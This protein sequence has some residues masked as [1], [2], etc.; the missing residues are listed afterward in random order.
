VAG[1]AVLVALSVWAL[2]AERQAQAAR[3]DAEA[4]QLGADAAL[5]VGEQAARIE[6]SALLAIEA[7][8]RRPALGNDM[9]L[10]AALRLLPE[11]LGTWSHAPERIAAACLRANG[12]WLVYGAGAQLFRRRADGSPA[13]APLPLEA[14]V[15]AIMP[16]GPADAFVVRTARPGGPVRLR[17]WAGIDAE[18]LPLPGA[19]AAACSADGRL[20]AMGDASGRI[21]L[22]ALDGGAAPPRLAESLDGPVEL[23]RISADGRLLAASARERLRLWTLDSGRPL[24]A[25]RL[26]RPIVDLDFAPDG[27]RLMAAADSGAY[28]WQL[29]EGRALR[30]LGELTNVHQARHAPDGAFIAL[31]VGDGSVVLYDTARLERVRQMRHQS[32]VHHLR[33]DHSGRRLLSAGND[34]TARL[35]RVDDG[36]EQLRFSHAGIVTA[37]D[38]SEAAGHILTAGR[39]GRLRLWRDRLPGRMLMDGPLRRTD[40]RLAGDQ[41][42]VAANAADI[43]EPLGAGQWALRTFG[44]TEP[45]LRLTTPSSIADFAL[46]PDRQV[47]ALTRF[48]RVIALHRISD[49]VLLAELRPGAMSDT[50]GFSPDGESLLTGSQDG[51]VRLWAWRDGAL[52]WQHAHAPFIFSHAF[53]ADG[54]Q[55]ATGGSDQTVHLLD[56]RDGALLRRWTLPSYPDADN[57][58]KAL[59]FDPAAP[60][61]AVGSSDHRVRLFRL[62]DGPPGPVLQHRSPVLALAFSPHGRWLASSASDD[63]IRLWLPD[64]GAERARFRAPDAAIALGFAGGLLRV[65]TG[66][67]WAAHAV[68]PEAVVAAACARLPPR[69][70]AQDGRDYL[71]TSEPAPTCPATP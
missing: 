58:V 47:I 43:L 14:P 63:M 20:L 42:R 38:W 54:R 45:L 46:S 64:E 33:F 10:R 2:L 67:E 59:A 49:G 18:P 22:L 48:D 40:T 66:G 36:S 25:K 31:G 1:V 41:V 71:G 34:G 53:S 21:T 28:L 50:L 11:P 4:R 37:I 13:P 61:L 12:Q 70:S 26:R 68:A 39:D 69:L 56:A 52:R 8:K 44:A 24:A 6:T 62:D 29:P 55:V 60:R 65:F 23:L 9:P 19:R 35:W 30:R 7:W 32:P 51:Q 3:R 17:Y 16:C 27:S 15:E 57:D 5:V